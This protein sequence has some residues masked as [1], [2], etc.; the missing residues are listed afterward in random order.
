MRSHPLS[1]IFASKKAS[2]AVLV[3]VGFLSNPVGGLAQLVPPPNR[4]AGQPPT[5]PPPVES[6]TITW[7]ERFQQIP[8][9]VAIVKNV[10][11]L[12]GD[13]SIG[14]IDDVRKAQRNELTRRALRLRAA[15]ALDDPNLALPKSAV[16]LLQAVAGLPVD[17]SNL[18]GANSTRP[19]VARLLG[20]IERFG[21]TQ[22]PKPPA[23]GG[24]EAAPAAPASTVNF[25][26]DAL[27]KF[28]QDVLPSAK[29]GGAVPPGGAASD[30]SEGAPLL[31]AGLPSNSPYLWP[32][33]VIPY[34]IE[35]GF[36]DDYVPMILSAMGLWEGH[37]PAGQARVH[38]RPYQY[39][40]PHWIQFRYTPGISGSSPVGMRSPA[41][42]GQ[43]INLPGANFPTPNI[44]H[45]VGHSIG[46]FHE[47]SRTDR[48]NYLQINVANVIRSSDPSV[49]YASQF[50]ITQE[51]S[52]NYGTFD[53]GSVMLYNAWA[54]STDYG[55][56]G[57]ET[58]IS[59]WPQISGPEEHWGLN[60]SNIKGP[61]AGDFSAVEA[62]YPVPASTSL[63]PIAQGASAAPNF[64]PDGSLFVGPPIM[65]G[66]PLSSSAPARGPARA[67][68][69]PP[70]A[71]PAGDP[72]PQGPG[73]V[74]PIPPLGPA[75]AP[76]PNG[77]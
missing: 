20:D 56:P 8:T 55:Q 66:P 19:D 24:G 30:P 27:L 42:S 12:E 69:R 71:P 77:S 59:L 65:G 31:A 23:A 22:L 72:A 36:P 40:D 37:W 67:G 63:A 61:S 25:P 10:A 9:R 51:P 16:D 2:L 73:P 50:L 46:L 1:G 3:V 70:L 47:Q 52:Q 45:E 39:G 48:D 64:I 17:S 21:L 49:S 26:F 34:Y 6:V 32:N 13:I 18:K 76:A 29:P 11:I 58:M 28:R 44:S 4:V 75:A 57:F 54:F 5:P 53:F 74:P 33:G 15:G 38:F 14:T 60:S 43:L 7:D 35:P 62:M 68:V 41:G